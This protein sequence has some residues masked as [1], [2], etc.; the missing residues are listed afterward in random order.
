MKISCFQP[1]NRSV[2]IFF[3]I[4]VSVGKNGNNGDPDDVLLVQF[5]LKKNGEL[6]P[7]LSPQAI[8]D[9]EIMK[10]VP[11]TGQIDQAT[12]DGIIAFQTARKRE[13]PG[14]IVDGRVSP[15]SHYMY[16]GDYFTIAA[17]NACLYQEECSSSLAAA[18]GLCRLPGSAQS[19]DSTD[20]VA[21]A[22]SA[23]ADLGN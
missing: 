23:V 3:N 14:T 10:K 21:P 6:V 2:L 8:Q 1:R 9:N 13:H 15:A 20:S 18:A 11:Q 12:I 16:G 4:D 7:A 19:E 17:M 22:L 5:L